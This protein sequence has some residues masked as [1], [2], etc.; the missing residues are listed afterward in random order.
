MVAE[1]GSVAFIHARLSD[2]M[3]AS[4]HSFVEQIITQARTG[5]QGMRENR[6]DPARWRWPPDDDADATGRPRWPAVR[7]LATYRLEATAGRR[8]SRR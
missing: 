5:A 7:K 3:P 6:P 2:R 1:H 8:T 4:I